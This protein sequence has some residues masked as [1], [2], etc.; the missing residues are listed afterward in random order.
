MDKK[1]SARIMQ[2]QFSAAGRRMI[3]VPSLATVLISLVSGLMLLAASCMPS[4][5][6]EQVKSIKVGFTNIYFIPCDGGLAPDRLSGIRETTG[7]TSKRPGRSAS[8]PRRYAISCSP[9][10]TTT[11]RDLRPSSFQNTTRSSSSTKRRWGRW[12]TA[13]RWRTC[14]RSTGALRRSFRSSRDFTRFVFPPFVPRE[15]DLIIGGDNGDILKR[16]RRSTA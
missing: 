8:I 10:T 4:H 15:T 9:T 16:D 11:T 7:S 6:P 14:G 2:K 12:R 5:R 1:E 3:I 13:R